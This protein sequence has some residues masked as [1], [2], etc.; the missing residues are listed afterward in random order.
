M[1]SILIATDRERVRTALAEALL[2]GGYGLAFASDWDLLVEGVARRQTRL[3]LIDAAMRGVEDRTGLLLQ[4]AESLHDSPTIYTLHGRLSGFKEVSARTSS[5]R[6]L[7]SR[8]VGPSVP[9]EERRLLKLVGVGPRPMNALA[10][11]SRSALPAWIHGERGTGKRQVVG[12][13]HRLGGRGALV[14]LE[15][16]PERALPW[17]E[18][19]ELMEDSQ[20]VGTLL[21]SLGEAW[22][23]DLLAEVTRKAREADLRLVVTARTSPLPGQGQWTQLHLPPLRERGRDLRSLTLHY[24]DVHRHAMGLPRRRIGRSLWALI[25]AH[26]WPGN[27]RELETFVVSTL[28][29]VDRTLLRAEDLPESVRRLV[30][31]AIGKPLEDEALAFEE[32]VEQRL[33]RVVGLYEPGGPKS[34]HEM[35]LG[36]TE[37]PLLRLVLARTGGNQKAAADLL[38]ISRNTLR[39]HLQAHGLRGRPLGDGGRS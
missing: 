4:V 32:M 17:P 7:A 26:R 28:S 9:R 36:G 37:K 12:A 38:G 35:V 27:A 24:I 34:L 5:L 11:V 6:R 15:P 22:S 29:S 31:P 21:L 20:S 25:Q 14:T 18:F 39:T 30:D 16:G 8:R 23:G 10:K 33:R 13:L 3:V 1:A 19:S 2:G